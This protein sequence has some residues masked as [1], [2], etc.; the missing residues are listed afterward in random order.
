M[1]HDSHDTQHHGADHEE[2]HHHEE[3]FISKYVFS[4]DHKM[5]G[6]QFLV[7]GIFMGVVGMILSM[8]FRTQ[9][10]WP[11]SNFTWLKP[12]LGGW[13]NETGKMDSSFYM[14]LVTIHGTIMVFY[15]LTAGLSGTFSNLLI[16]LQIGARDMASPFINMLSYW[17][18]FMS[19]V[20]LLI[21]LFLSS[22]PAAP[23]WTIYPPL[24]ALPKA[25]PGS[26]MGMTLWL[27][28]MILFIGS[29][30]MGGMNYIATILNMRTK[31]MSMTRLPLTIW[32]FFLTAILGLLSF[33]VLLGGSLLLLFDRSFGTMFYLSDIPLE[34]T[35]GIERVGGSPILFQHLFWF[36]GHP[37]VYIIL[38]PALGLTSEIISTNARKPIFGYRAMIMSLLAIAFLSFIVWGHH[39]FITGMNPF[40]GSVFVLATL[41]IAVPSAIKVFNYLATLWRGNIRLTPA[42][43]FAIGLVSFFISGGLTGL[44]LGNAA[45]DIQ[46][47]DS[48]FVVAHFHIVMGTAAI[49][50]MI[51]GVY[52]WFPKFYRRRMDDRLGSLHFWL[53]IVSAYGV[54][55][56]MH[57]MGLAGVPR[58]YYQFTLL[59][60]FSVWNDLNVF[61]T[62]MGLLGAF[63]QIIFLYNFFNS[64]FNGRKTEQNPWNSNTLEWTAPIEHMHG[65]WPGEIPEVHRW[66]YDYSVPGA[67]NDFIPQNIPVGPHENHHDV[68]HAASA[69]TSTQT[70]DEG[71]VVHFSVPSFLQKLLGFKKVNL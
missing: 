44:Y 28:A 68:A 23:G 51:A 25:M 31:G 1:S 37:E 46:L 21:S 63:A 8:I 27:I 49:F 58:R 35:G 29:A 52:H 4:M 6:K 41:I 32:A 69:A 24:S 16:P 62:I 12:I 70:L 65:N 45:L 33:P 22:G 39:M 43:C 53:T 42:M 13:I 19:S 11:D 64:I 55:F 34:L 66:P 61:I 15:V 14:S 3:T 60:E 48:Y 17:F 26:G 67:E 57:F 7:T 20:V 40:L 18:F 30:L 54:F 59:D 2:H 47:H 36:L 56:P 71:G 38:L 10:A 5:I 9:L 50:G